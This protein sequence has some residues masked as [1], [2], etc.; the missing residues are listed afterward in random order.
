MPFIAYWPA[1]I[2]GGRVE[3][4]MAMGTDLMPT[5]LEIL[6]LPAPGDRE[7]DGRSLL[8]VRPAAPLASRLP[9][10]LDGETLFAARDQRFKYQGAGGV[11]IPPTKCPSVRASS[12]RN[13][14]ST[15]RRMSRSLTTSDRHPEDLQRLRAAF[16][17]KFATWRRT[18]GAG[19]DQNTLA[20]SPTNSRPQSQ[21]AQ[22]PS[23]NKANRPGYQ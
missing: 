14:C 18:S 20:C 16:D 23:Q 5:L 15:C 8:E 21:S 11:F 6:D 12:K 7:L 1:A 19:A 22:E 13:G 17:A 2:P 9:V 3:T 4:A 10:L